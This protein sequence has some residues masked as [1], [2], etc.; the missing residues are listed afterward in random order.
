MNDKNQDEDK[1]QPLVEVTDLT[2]M[3]GVVTALT[4]KL[5]RA[6][7]VV[8]EPTKIRRKAKAE[9]EAAL[10]KAKSDIDIAE[11]GK[12]S[13]LRAHY[14][15]MR[16]QANLEAII[17][18]AINEMRD[19]NATP[20]K[21]GDDWLHLYTDRA[22]YFSEETARKRWAKLLA[23]EAQKPGS[24]S[25]KTMGILFAMTQSDAELFEKFCSFAVNMGGSKR[26]LIFD[27]TAQI[28]SGHGV[29]YDTVQHLVYLGLITYAPSGLEGHLRIKNAALA[30]SILIE[31]V[32]FTINATMPPGV[33]KIDGGRVL[34]TRA[35]EELLGICSAS[36]VKGFP[37]YII[38][39][40]NGKGI[41]CKLVK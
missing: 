37:D 14:Q 26:P 35:G 2:G 36:P 17:G 6:V 24:F 27:E 29:N 12:R 34:F 8:Y 20:E 38:D 28:Y 18:E 11:L 40:Y 4:D 3:G 22:K 16:E 25:P 31:G 30:T 15:G 10:I 41:T 5:E 21:M 39:E 33:A 9:A 32:G 23:G 13:E 7:G 19:K 1:A